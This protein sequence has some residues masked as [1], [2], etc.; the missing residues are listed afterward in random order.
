MCLLLSQ[1]CFEAAIK[2]IGLHVKFK[3]L[4]SVHAVQAWATLRERQCTWQCARHAYDSNLCYPV[5]NTAS[6]SH[7]RGGPAG[8]TPSGKVSSGLADVGML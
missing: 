8:V 4:H 3:A 7:C 5:N 1:G 2:F 6:G